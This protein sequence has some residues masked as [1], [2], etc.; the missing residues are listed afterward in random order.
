MAEFQRAGDALPTTLKP[1]PGSDA[2][3][4]LTCSAPSLP[5]AAQRWQASLTPASPQA[6]AVTMDRLIGFAQAFG[7][8][9]SD[10][11]AALGFYREALGDLPADLLAQAVDATIS[12]HRYHVLPKPGEIRQHVTEELEHREDML[13]RYTPRSSTLALPTP[14]A[15]AGG[16]PDD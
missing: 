1:Q 8:P 5:P 13:R 14:T 6:F 11:K 10:L 2:R 15:S 3:Q 16:C 7:L 4:S 9:A 12:T